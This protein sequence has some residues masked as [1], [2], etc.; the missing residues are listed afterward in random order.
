MHIVMVE[1]VRDMMEE[2]VIEVMEMEG[3]EMFTM[4]L[5]LLLLLKWRCEV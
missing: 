5:L 3:R 2:G 1:A 4:L